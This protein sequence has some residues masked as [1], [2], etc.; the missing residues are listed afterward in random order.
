METP[1]PEHLTIYNSALEQTYKV[2]A[3]LWTL[4]VKQG[5]YDPAYEGSIA[6]TRREIAKESGK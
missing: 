5:G 3:K 2:P 4:Y 1:P 6:K